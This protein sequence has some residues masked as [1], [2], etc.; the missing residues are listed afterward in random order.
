MSRAEE[1]RHIERRAW[2]WRKEVD[3]EA[4]ETSRTAA[5]PAGRCYHV[6]RLPLKAEQARRKEIEAEVTARLD[7]GGDVDDE[8]DEPI[9]GLYTV[10]K[11]TAFYAIP[12]LEA[13][14]V[15]KHLPKEYLDAINAL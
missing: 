6:D 12:L 13:D 14:L 9:V 1:R 3:G 10:A 2:E 15:K 4:S 5:I 11:P 7:A 8:D